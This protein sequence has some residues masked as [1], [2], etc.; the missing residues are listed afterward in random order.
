[1]EEKKKTGFPF[2][3]FIVN[4]GQGASSLRPFSQIQAYIVTRPKVIYFFWYINIY[5]SFIE[6]K[7]LISKL[8]NP[9]NAPVLSPSFSSFKFY[10]FTENILNCY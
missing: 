7:N 8:K 2:N 4:F 10:L 6:I 1:M 9:R 5:L 3:F